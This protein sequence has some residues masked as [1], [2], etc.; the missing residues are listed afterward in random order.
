[1]PDEALRGVGLSGQKLGYMR[2]LSARVES[3]ALQ[4]RT[5]GPSPTR[6]SSRR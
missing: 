5:L 1:V 4:L 6:T 2:D 3:G